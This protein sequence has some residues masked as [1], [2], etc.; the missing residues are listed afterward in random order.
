[1]ENKAKPKKFAVLLIAMIAVLFISI[2]Y[3]SIILL[4]NQRKPSSVAPQKTKAGSIT[5]SKLIA[6][7]TTRSTPSATPTEILLAVK[8]P[9]ITQ[10]QLFPSPSFTVTPTRL[11]T[12]VFTSPSPTK[13]VTSLPETGYVTN[14]LVLFSVASLLI[15]F[16]LLF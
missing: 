10:T 4:N 15:L 7:N 1:M 2:F 16:S 9:S 11:P 5:Y 3:I 13:T 12:T 14:S 6:L 8:S